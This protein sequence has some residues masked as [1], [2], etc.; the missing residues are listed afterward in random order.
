[1][2]EHDLGLLREEKELRQLLSNVTIPNGYRYAELTSQTQFRNSSIHMPI[3]V[4]DS[5]KTVKVVSYNS[6]LNIYE[7]PFAL[8]AR[9]LGECS[10][11]TRISDYIDVLKIEAKSNISVHGTN[12]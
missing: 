7:L 10:L 12:I 3:I 1:M 5:E 8:E 11:P 9:P 4:N 6:I 2:N